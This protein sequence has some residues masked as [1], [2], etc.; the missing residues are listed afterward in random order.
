M[1]RKSIDEMTPYELRRRLT[2]LTKILNPQAEVADRLIAKMSPESLRTMIR[3][4]E[5][6][7]QER[8]IDLV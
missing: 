5:Y 1:D 2:H 7:C 4:S 3:I 6:A 8:G